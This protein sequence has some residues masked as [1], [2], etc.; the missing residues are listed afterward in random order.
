[1]AQGADRLASGGCGVALM[2]PW[3]GNKLATISYWKL[4]ILTSQKNGTLVLSAITG[5][6][7][8]EVPADQVRSQGTTWP[9]NPGD[10]R[11]GT[12][13]RANR[14][15]QQRY[16]DPV[17][18]RFLTVNYTVSN[19]HGLSEG[20]L[21][22]MVK[23]LH[24]MVRLLY[25]VMAREMT[26]DRLQYQKEY[27]G[28]KC[29]EFEATTNKALLMAHRENCHMVSTKL[30]RAAPVVM[31]LGMCVTFFVFMLRYGWYTTSQ[32]AVA[33]YIGFGIFLVGCGVTWLFFPSK[34]LMFAVCLALFAYP[35]LYDVRNFV[36]LDWKFT[37]FMSVC[38]L[39]L[40]AAIEMRRR[41]H[42]Q[43]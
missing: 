9:D 15:M 17:A 16:Y 39:L 22:D 5:A 42:R 3:A 34:V 27:G 33:L 38:V 35:P 25:V 41:T 10:R 19:A 36:G 29:K 20:L 8:Y 26:G 21:S 24:R 6:G 37:P 14:H 2:H 32:N 1:M 30:N 28:H 31:L 43:E 40:I 7:M 18:G 12:V 4:S 13:A 11:G 23:F